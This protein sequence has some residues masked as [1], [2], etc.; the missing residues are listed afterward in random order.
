MCDNLI[1]EKAPYHNKGNSVKSPAPKN[2]QAAL[3]NSV[4]IKPTSPRRIGV[5]E[6]EIVISDQHRPCV[7][8]GHVRTWEQLTNEMKSVLK[9]KLID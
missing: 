6:N 9:K 2:G 8:H 3:N 7:F 5:S 1:Y 4:Q